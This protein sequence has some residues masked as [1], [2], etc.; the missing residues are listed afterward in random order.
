MSYVVRVHYSR[1]QLTKIEAYLWHS[2]WFFFIVIASYPHFL[3]GIAET[4]YF[5]RVFD[6][7][8]VGAFMCLSFISIK[9]HYKYREIEKKID[10]IVKNKALDRVARRNF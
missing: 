6:L 8:V 7:L 2:L 1:A 10:Q 3:T 4:F 9:N 5:D